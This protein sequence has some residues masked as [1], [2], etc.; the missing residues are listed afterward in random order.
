MT[1]NKNTHTHISV[2]SI[3]RIPMDMNMA[4]AKMHPQ[5][6]LT[7][8]AT[9]AISTS[10]SWLVNWCCPGKNGQRRNMPTENA[11]KPYFFDDF[12]CDIG[13]RQPTCQLSQHE[14]WLN[15]GKMGFTWTLE[16]KPTF[17]CRNIWDS[18]F[19]LAEF[20]EWLNGW[21]RIWRTAK[22]PKQS[23]HFLTQSKW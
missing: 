14:W 4:S 5:I 6:N 17:F 15:N 22:N 18:S 1:D 19:F 8:S 10:S 12:T 2:Y 11:G 9:S 20:W 23:W 21:L 7:S 3:G 13:F 16:R